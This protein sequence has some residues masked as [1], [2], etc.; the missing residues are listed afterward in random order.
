[1]PKAHFAKVQLEQI[2]RKNSKFERIMMSTKYTTSR[3]R[4]LGGILGGCAASL[5][6]REI[7]GAAGQSDAGA[8][9]QL[10]LVDYHVHLDNSSIEQVLPLSKERGVKFGIVEHAGTR[11][12]KYP[13][14]L[15]N[16]DELGAYLKKLEGKDVY[17]G[18]QAEWTD[19]AGCFSREALGRLD[20]ILTDAMTFPGKDG[21]RVKLWEKGVKERVDMS[22]RQGF[23]DRFVDWHVQIITTEP[24][25]ILGNVSWL[26]AGLAEDYDSYWTEARIR[27]VVDAAVKYGVAM[28]ISSSFKLPKL[29]FLKIA[30]GAGVKFAF[31]SNGRYP[32]MGLLEYSVAAARDLELKRSDLFTPGPEGHKAA[33]RRK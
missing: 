16:D 5:I 10:P 26:P 19:W 20:Y 27:K 29:K 18:V 15:S 11:E 23:M 17:K 2:Q 24:I 22:D 8:D 30:K 9:N 32:R 6:G 33:Q 1:M 25:D 13:V 7:S 4:F 3:R 28:E 21:Q 14:V 12:N 31:G